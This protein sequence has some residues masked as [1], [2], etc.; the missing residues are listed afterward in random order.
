MQHFSCVSGSAPPP[1][2]CSSLFVGGRNAGLGRK[3]WHRS[4][5]RPPSPSACLPACPGMGAGR[6]QIHN[7]SVCF[8]IV[9]MFAL[10]LHNH[11]TAW[12]NPEGVAP[13][14]TESPHHFGLWK[15]VFF[16]LRHWPCWDSESVAR[17]SPLRLFLVVCPHGLL[18]L[19]TLTTRS[20]EV[21]TFQPVAFQSESQLFSC[22]IAGLKQVGVT[23][24]YQDVLLFAGW[25][26]A[27]K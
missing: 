26:H 14:H 13:P 7:V 10:L 11:R 24:G 3:L 20:C 2:V 27:E 8:V 25:H 17:F 19:D 1:P 5:C 22:V 4:L 21:T 23:A 15:P 9:C 12:P 16:S 6:W 18:C